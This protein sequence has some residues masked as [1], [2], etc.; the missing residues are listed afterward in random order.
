MRALRCRP[1]ESCQI[2]VHTPSLARVRSG[3]APS[4][5]H[6]K[7]P[8]YGRSAPLPRP[9]RPP[10]PL[11]QAPSLGH[12]GSRPRPPPLPQPHP[13]IRRTRGLAV[14]RRPTTTPNPPD[15]RPRRLATA[16]PSRPDSRPCSTTH[17][18]TARHL[19]FW[20]RV[21]RITSD[22]YDYIVLKKGW[23]TLQ[24]NCRHPPTEATLTYHPNPPPKRACG[25]DD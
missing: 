18:A 20:V 23:R 4:P 1:S 13:Q 7:P 19:T 17:L 3:L 14:R 8:F 6:P 11:P 16:P 12:G 21:H 25:A 24:Q 10:P 9:L 2:S 22:Y 15:S 5:I